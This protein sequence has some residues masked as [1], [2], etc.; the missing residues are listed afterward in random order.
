MAGL[1]VPRFESLG[2]GEVGIKIGIV[3]A[4]GQVWADIIEPTTAKA[5]AR[6]AD[7]RKFYSGLPCVTVNRHG[8]GYVWYIGTSLDSIGIFLL[9]RRILKQAGVAPRFLGMGIEAVERITED[10]KKVKVVLNHTP[11]VKFAFGR[12]IPAYGWAVLE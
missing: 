7:R 9:Y 1:R 10:G 2:T 6:Y 3:K 8:S 11:K 12:R 5:A 4:R